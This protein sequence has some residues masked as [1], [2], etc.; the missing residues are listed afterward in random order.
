MRES[1]TE[2]EPGIPFDPG[3][4]HDIIKLWGRERERERQTDRESERE[5]ER[6]IRRYIILV[7]DLRPFSW[8]G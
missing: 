1:N 3:M 5:R 7:A 8:W 6:E 4:S 2:L